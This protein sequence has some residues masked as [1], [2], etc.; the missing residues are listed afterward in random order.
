MSSTVTISSELLDHIVNALTRLPYADVIPVLQ[1]LAEELESKK[2]AAE[3]PQ[4]I[5]TR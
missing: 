3:Q 4:I 5:Q 2:A 1:M